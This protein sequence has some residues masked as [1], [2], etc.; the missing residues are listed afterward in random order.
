MY[1]PIVVRALSTDSP[2]SK[3]NDRLTWLLTCFVESAR[4][5]LQDLDT[6]KGE[7]KSAEEYADTC[8]F[9]E[10][11][12]NAVHVFF[13]LTNVRTDFD[14]LDKLLDVRDLKTTE[15]EK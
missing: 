10:R 2:A 9:Q 14:G 12:R 11:F 13:V 8:E 5:I 1:Q 3:L 4:L 6:I 15:G 7:A